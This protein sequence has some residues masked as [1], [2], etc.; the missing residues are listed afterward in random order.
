MVMRRYVIGEDGGLSA[1]C[2]CL[3]NLP[4]TR[5]RSTVL[6]DAGWAACWLD[7]SPFFSRVEV[8]RARVAGG[9]GCDGGF[10]SAAYL[11]CQRVSTTNYHLRALV[12]LV[13]R[14]GALLTTGTPS[15]PTSPAPCPSA[16]PARGLSPVW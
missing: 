7:E 16:V 4:R 1:F 3:Q 5:L 13:T 14:V 2:C 10:G 15:A 6:V 12:G 9:G 11:S 8:S